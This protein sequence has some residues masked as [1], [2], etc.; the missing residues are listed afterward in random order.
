MLSKINS[1]IIGDQEAKD[2]TLSFL[3]YRD[4]TQN[5]FSC[6]DADR[7]LVFLPKATNST[8]DFFFKILFY[9]FMRGTERERER[10]RGSRLHAGSPMWDPILGLQNPAPG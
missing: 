4:L 7:H 10:G 6:W 1:Y 8:T 5:L 9:L 3:D 2:I